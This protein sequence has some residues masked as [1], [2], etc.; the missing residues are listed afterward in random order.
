M[1]AQD[2]IICRLAESKLQ[3]IDEGHAKGF[4]D[5]RAKGFNEACTN[6]ITKALKRG[7]LTLEEI[8]EDNDVSIDRVREIQKNLPTYTHHN[9][10]C[11]QDS[12]AP[13][14]RKH[15][16]PKKDAKYIP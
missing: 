4:N 5:G 13:L 15:S 2:E 9:V 11:T 10:P 3:G 14:M 16:Y 6:A 7:K 1:I 8:A 12:F